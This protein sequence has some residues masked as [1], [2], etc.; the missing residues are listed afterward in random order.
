[1]LSS[2][3]LQFQLGAIILT[4]LLIIWAQRVDGHTVREYGLDP[5]I[6]MVSD[7]TAGLIIGSISVGVM[8]LLVASPAGLD[9]VAFQNQAFNT[10]FGLF[11]LKAVIVAYWEETVFRGFLLVNLRK[12]FSA[13]FG[14]TRGT[15]AAVATSSLLF[16]AIHS[17]TDHFSWLALTIL[18]LNGVVWC[19]PMLLTGRLGM[20]I[21]L[22]AS[23]NFS[24]SKIFGFAMS[25]NASESALLDGKLT[26][27][28]IWTGGDYGPEG[29]LV[30][31]VGLMAMFALI[32]AYA[33]WARKLRQAA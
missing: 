30:G 8:F 20:S 13:A 26:G 24:Q 22:H 28:E 19:I 21:G 4:G 5:S 33:F 7:G 25:G 2:N 27:W 15:V 3:L 32:I 18:T 31:I 16:G 23:W 29:G 6:P 11:F 9:S 12:S 17:G 14:K 1:M 10:A